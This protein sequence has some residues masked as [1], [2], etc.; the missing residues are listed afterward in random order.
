MHVLVNYLVQIPAAIDPDVLD[1]ADREDIANALRCY[2]EDQ[3]EHYQGDVFDWRE[4]Y[5]AGGWKNEY[6]E[7]VLFASSDPEV[8]VDRLMHIREC[9]RRTI[10][11]Y[12]DQIEQ[13]YGTTDLVQI[14]KQSTD[15]NCKRKAEW[16]LCQLAN[17]LNGRLTSGS[18]FF[19]CEERT[20]VISDATL[21]KIRQNPEKWA[22]V[23]FD[24]HS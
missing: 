23:L 5:T 7:N 16:T 19:D 12:L 13:V 20:T 21:D 11:A 3:T 15:P 24:Q 18:D 14:A 9:Q 2:V 1:K 4:T 8:F 10:A 6:P 17:E 22:V